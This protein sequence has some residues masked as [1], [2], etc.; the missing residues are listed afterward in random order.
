MQSC[1]SKG[2]DF[3]VKQE[4]TSNEVGLETKNFTVPADR[5][6]LHSPSQSNLSRLDGE[7]LEKCQQPSR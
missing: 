3:N 7:L 2:C 1:D 5:K 6:E 4:S